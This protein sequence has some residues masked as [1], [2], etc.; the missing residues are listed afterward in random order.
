MKTLLFAT[1]DG[2]ELAPLTR[3][4]CVALL[5]V[6]GK[7]LIVHAIESL[8]MA[9]LAEVIIVT[10]APQLSEVAKEVG[11]G[12]R[13]GMRFEHF[14]TALAD[15]LDDVVRQLSERLNDE[16]LVVCGDVL[17]TPIVSEFLARA[18]MSEDRAVTATIGGVGAGVKFFRSNK[19]T[20]GT[21]M[22]ESL[23][24]AGSRVSLSAIEF[25]VARLS[26]I[27]SL[28]AFHRANID[29][30]SGGFPGLVLA[31]RPLAP[32]ITVGRKTRLP[33]RS[34]T[35]RMVFVGSRCR[36]SASAE[37]MD[38]VVVSDDVL[39]D[40]LV[41]LKSAVIMPNTYIGEFLEVSDAIVQGDTLIHID[42]GGVTHVSEPL[43]LRSM[44]AGVLGKSEVGSPVDR[45]S[46]A[47]N[48]S[49]IPSPSRSGTMVLNV[50]RGFARALGPGPSSTTLSS[51]DNSAKS[52]APSLAFTLTA[53]RALAHLFA[54]FKRRS[55]APMENDLEGREAK[56]NVVDARVARE[57]A[58][59]V[60]NESREPMRQT[61]AAA[62]AGDEIKRV[63]TFVATAVREEFRRSEAVATF[64]KGKS[65]TQSGKGSN[66][67]EAV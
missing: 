28:A 67:R 58:D 33:A 64:R 19:M 54:M 24:I 48:N 10:R 52:D 3:D 18:R 35:G 46:S 4:R 9:A 32:G 21:A 30:A 39:I 49:A 20:S 6:A 8:A 55:D 2:S 26:R 31:G 25:P 63:E 36:I 47:N 61:I 23:S 16:L 56:V 45:V 38:D 5:P 1:R 17:R 50:A 44:R 27:E 41:T 13:W 22:G 15:S 37:L 60:R 43:L 29:A 57:E 59:R 66:T 7:P 11:N 65:A 53:V 34:V 14:P 62:S 51:S 12:A 42:A 40:R